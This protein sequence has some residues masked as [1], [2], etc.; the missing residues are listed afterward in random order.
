M[1]LSAP[2][3]ID[4]RQGPVPLATDQVHVWRIPLADGTEIAE[5]WAQA[6]SSDEL[7]QAGR[8]RFERDRQ[9]YA[10]AHAVMRAVLANYLRINPKEVQYTKNEYSKPYLADLTALMFNLSHSNDLALLAITLEREVGVDVEFIRPDLAG[11]G[12]AQ[13]YFAP[14]EVQALAELPTDQQASAFFNCW[15]R[16]EAIIKARGAGL[17]LPLDEFEVSIYPTSEEVTFKTLTDP[18][19]AKHWCIR[20]FEPASGY[21]GAL[22]ARGRDWAPVLLDWSGRL[23]RIK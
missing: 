10:D 22:A 19:P 15:T 4:F 23:P 3:W 5:R 14:A 17:S 8:F 21:T 9:H 13:R 16:K 20:A 1:N 18:S 6:L 12:V 2:A 11:M 7:E